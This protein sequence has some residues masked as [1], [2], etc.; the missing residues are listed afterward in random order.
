MRTTWRTATAATL[1][2]L[3]VAGLSACGGSSDGGSSGGDSPAPE[4]KAADLDPKGALEAAATAMTRAGS[5]SMATS[6]VAPPAGGGSGS[7]SGQGGSGSYTWKSP[8]AFQMSMNNGSRAEITLY[9]DGTM[10]FGG[11]KISAHGNGKKWLTYD[12]TT[13]PTMKKT[14][15]SVPSP[16]AMTEMREFYNPVAQLTANAKAGRLTKVGNE[17]VGGAK[18]VHIQSFIQTDAWAAAVPGLP[19]A[20]Q[21]DVSGAMHQKSATY[22]FWIDEQNR[23]VQ[24]RVSDPG[25]PYKPG[26]QTTYSAYGA[27]PEIA[28]PPASEV[29]GAAELSKNL[30]H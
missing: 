12:S 14:D 7:S 17:T 21:K 28:T 15:L 19:A 20:R 30:R 24:V 3:L 13:S 8:E 10:Y 9:V 6:S 29:L 22:D 27:A 11:D 4:K 23:L 26:I 1:S 25:L 5:A 16:A 18:T 2:A